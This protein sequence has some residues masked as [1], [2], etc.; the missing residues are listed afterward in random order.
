MLSITKTYYRSYQAVMRAVI[1]VA[2][3]RE[4]E[5]VS[6][7]GSLERLPGILK[8]AGI[9]RIL[10]VASR[11][12]M[13]SGC[14]EAFFKG[15]EAEGIASSVYDRVQPNPSID[16][17][18]DCLRA[19]RENRSG[20]IVAIGGGSPIDCAKVVA[21]RVACPGRPIRA[22]RGYLKVRGKLPPLYAVPTTAGSGSEATI[23]AVVTDSATHE[24]YAITDFKLVPGCSV[25]DPRLTVGLPADTTAATGMDAL[26]HAVEAYIGRDGTPFTDA[27]A[28]DAVKLIFANLEI[29]YREGSN[30][31]ARSAMLLASNEAGAAFTRAFVGYVHAVAHSLGGLYGVAHGLANAIALPYVLEYYGESAE[32]RLADLAIAVGLDKTEEPGTDLAAAF[33]HRI[34]AMNAAMGIPES[35]KELQ[36]KDIPLLVKR[37][38]RE[39]NPAYPVPRIM[40]ADDCAALLGRL[41]QRKNR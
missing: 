32:A 41:I 29:A 30:L 13:K 22:L 38:L 39:A 7:A 5:L 16:N 17:I 12:M 2:N 28:K 23:A 24:K 34:R 9:E 1:K 4:P 40:D 18:E 3:I 21:A 27:K 8:G 37:I 33:I 15:L 10:V 14:L 31:K 20:A 19:Y 26:T 25:L 36:E 6:G 35:V 11:S